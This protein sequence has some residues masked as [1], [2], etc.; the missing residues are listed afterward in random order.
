MTR[1]YIL[2][3]GQTEEA[4]FRELLSPYFARMKCYITPI[5]VSTS[6]GHKGGVISYAKIRPQITRLCLEQKTLMLV[7]CLICMHYHMIFQVSRLQNI[8][9][10]HQVVKK[11]CL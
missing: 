10:Q 1:I 4:F 9:K 11:H 7:P 3:E 6:K 8:Q 2:V 5:I